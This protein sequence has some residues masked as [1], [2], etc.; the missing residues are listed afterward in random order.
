VR[1]HITRS[2]PNLLEQ[3]IEHSQPIT[4]YRSTFSIPS[5]PLRNVYE[6][7]GPRARREHS[8][9]QKRRHRRHCRPHS[10]QRLQIHI[11][12]PNLQLHLDHSR[13][14]SLYSHQHASK[15][16]DSASILPRR[17][18]SSS[19]KAKQQ[20]WHNSQPSSSSHSSQ[21]STSQQSSW[22]AQS[23]TAH[24]PAPSSSQ[25]TRPDDQARRPQ[26]HRCPA[27]S[28]VRSRSSNS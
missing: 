3:A 21:L 1:R 12:I 26:L 13:Q 25:S 19:K 24:Q 6:E 28:S 2:K 20:T 5:A 17:T 14:F 22:T 4:V 11:S 16:A 27:T 18:T 8:S 10:R 23:S 15:T 7:L 9:A